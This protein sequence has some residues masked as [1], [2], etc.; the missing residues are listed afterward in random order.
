MTRKKRE[1]K[2]KSDENIAYKSDIFATRP[3]SFGV[4]AESPRPCAER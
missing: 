1:K 4:D 2:N 3:G